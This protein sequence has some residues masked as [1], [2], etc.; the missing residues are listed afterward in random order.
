MGKFI[1]DAF[2]INLFYGFGSDNSLN[3]TFD[4]VFLL[5]FFMLG[6]GGGGGCRLFCHFWGFLHG[7]ILPNY[8]ILET[9]PRQYP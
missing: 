9:M 8:V 4:G 7:K 2:F 3:L 5:S 1:I 6:G